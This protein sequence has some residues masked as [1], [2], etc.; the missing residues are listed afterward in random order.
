MALMESLSTLLQFQVAGC[1]SRR[2]LGDRGHRWASRTESQS[3]ALSW[4]LH[5]F[6]PAQAFPV[7]ALAGGA[8]LAGR[9]HLLSGLDQVFMSQNNGDSSRPRGGA[10]V[11]SLEEYRRRLPRSQPEA[12]AP[13]SEENSKTVSDQLAFGGSR[14]FWLDQLRSAVML[15]VA[16]TPIRP[17][18]EFFILRTRLDGYS[19]ELTSILGL[20]AIRRPLAA[21]LLAARLDL[22]GDT[23]WLRISPKVR[24]AAEEKVEDRYPDRFEREEIFQRGL[25]RYLQ[26]A[27]PQGRARLDISESRLSFEELPAELAEAW[28]DPL[29]TDAQ[30]LHLSWWLGIFSRP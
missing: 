1:L 24:L 14:E 5:H 6:P 15:W 23:S 20:L 11:I 25:D 27:A 8:R 30:F 22:V 12:P 17:N 19:P 2:L 16:E 21:Q 3:R 18:R 13:R 10:K 4:N 26:V 28:H 9:P 29:L 7:L